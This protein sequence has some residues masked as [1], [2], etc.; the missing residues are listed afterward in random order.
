MVVLRL[1]NNKDN[2]SLHKSPYEKNSQMLATQI[3][4]FLLNS[5]AKS[6]SFREGCGIEETLILYFMDF[7][8]F[9]RIWSLL[10]LVVDGRI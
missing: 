9:L 2:F 6:F 10:E 4:S 1:K 3:N 7:I 5:K 8:V